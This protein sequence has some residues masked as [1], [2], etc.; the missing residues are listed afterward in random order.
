MRTALKR[1]LWLPLLLMF[2]ALLAGCLTTLPDAGT[3]GPGGNGGNPGNGGGNSGP[4]VPGPTVV[5]RE[6][7]IAYT[8][9]HGWVEVRVDS[10]EAKVSLAPGAIWF[11]GSRLD[12]DANAIFR[13]RDVDIPPGATILEAKVVM[14]HRPVPPGQ[15][16]NQKPVKVDI[17]GF[18]H[19]N[20]PRFA[21]IP[22]LSAI[23]RTE[24]SVLWTIEQPWSTTEAQEHET[25]DLSEII[26]E[27]VNRPGWKAGNALGI[28]FE[29]GAHRNDQRYHREICVLGS[30]LEA[31]R[32]TQSP[33]LYVRYVI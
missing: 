15:S 4:D 17:H 26:Q 16:V 23:P 12:Y 6:F 5:T 2:I 19:D 29:T 1:Q 28:V 14:W 10:G 20:L 7:P 11:G 31:C 3:G 9:D 27:I 22:D 18:A 8:E 13:W 21:H 32:G 25:P 33:V 24:V 30:L